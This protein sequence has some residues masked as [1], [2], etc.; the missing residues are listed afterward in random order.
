M[1]LSIL[2]S[3]IGCLIAIVFFVFILCIY[4]CIVED[5][6]EKKRIEYNKWNF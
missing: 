6:E 5:I 2:A 3:A 1:L 4:D